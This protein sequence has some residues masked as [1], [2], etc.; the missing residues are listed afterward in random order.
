[1]VKL[2]FFKWHKKTA[3]VKKNKPN[4]TVYMI[5]SVQKVTASDYNQHKSTGKLISCGRQ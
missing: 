2:F 1:M 5:R 4:I 3:T